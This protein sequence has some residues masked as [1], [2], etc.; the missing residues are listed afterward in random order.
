MKQETLQDLKVVS[1]ASPSVKELS[2]EE[3][4]STWINSGKNKKH[5]VSSTV[6]HSSSQPAATAEPGELEELP[7]LPVLRNPT[8]DE[9]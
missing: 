2:P 9:A 4:I 6:Q 7:P 1:T 3:A 5:F 8:L